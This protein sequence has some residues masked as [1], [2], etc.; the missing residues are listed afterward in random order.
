MLVSLLS[1]GGL[2][3]LLGSS[4]KLLGII[5][6][7]PLMQGRLVVLIARSV[8]GLFY[9]LRVVFRASLSFRNIYGCLGLSRKGREL[10]FSSSF[11]S[12]SLNRMAGIVVFFV[13]GNA[14]M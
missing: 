4:I 2:P 8:I 12:L 9:Y 5:I 13:L 10:G 7:F 11:L 14:V 3:P 6:L 1:L